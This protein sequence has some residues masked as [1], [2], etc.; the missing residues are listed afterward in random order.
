MAAI[1]AMFASINPSV[2]D[3]ARLEG[4]LADAINLVASMQYQPATVLR[5]FYRSLVNVFDRIRQCGK[6]DGIDFNSTTLKSLLFGPDL[7]VEAL[8][9]VR[10]DA[11][12][13]IRKASPALALK[14]KEDVGALEILEKS[15]VVR[16]RLAQAS[17][18]PLAKGS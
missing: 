13:A 18:E 1:E 6:G 7:G 3:G 9:L 14:M 8:R 4:A 10:A 17:K 16:D 2:L 15:S 5:V 11:I 12:V